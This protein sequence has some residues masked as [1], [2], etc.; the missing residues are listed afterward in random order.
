MTDVTPSGEP[1]TETQARDTMPDLVPVPPPDAALRYKEDHAMD[2]LRHAPRYRNWLILVLTSRR[3]WF[4]IVLVVAAAA[5]IIIPWYFWYRAPELPL[6]VAVVDKTVPFMNRRNHRGLFWLLGQ[7]KFV[8]G[9]L[10]G[11][12]RWYMYDRDYI[13]FFPVELSEVDFERVE[14]G[15]GPTAEGEPAEAGDQQP[16]GAAAAAE[17]DPGQP[18]ETTTGTIRAIGSWKSTLLDAELLADRDVLYLA[19]T[20]GVYTGDY[21]QFGEGWAST[22]HTEKIFGGM[23][24]Q[25]A[26]AVEQ[27]AAE[28]KLIVAEFNCFASPTPDDIRARMEH[29]L[30]VSWTR[31]IGRYF[32]D[33]SDVKD[34]PYWLLELWEQES[35]RT[36]DLTGSGYMLCRDESAEFI[37]LKDGEDV[38]PRHGMKLV[39]RPLFMERDVLQGVKPCTFAYW[40]DI[41]EPGPNTETLADYDFHVTP[42][43]QAKLEEHGLKSV[44]PAIMRTQQAY[45]PMPEP[46]PEVVEEAEPDEAAAEEA[47]DGEPLAE[48]PQVPMEPPEGL[49]YTVYYL[50][51]DMVDFDK[52]MGP[53][54]TRLT[55]YINRSFHA[56][57][58]V[59]SQGYFFWHTY[60]PL[61]TNILR[62]ESYRQTG[63]PLNIYLF[64]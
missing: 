28:G 1:G 52:A 55:M 18:P 43:G 63:E 24:E 51:G 64:D 44:F 7:N 60:Y 12:E 5:S 38:M 3:F 61:M 39:P 14:N 32:L 42:Q 20:Y 15:N 19:D 27:F 33:F 59:G 30:G 13:G 46:L 36:W 11:Q 45:A 37:I 4:V 34:V 29:V 56:Q 62:L 2:A 49:Y 47:R 9:G 50:A 17:P 25:E 16:A 22:M 35:G 21:T 8:D 57:H 41:V 6:G 53:S 58:V 31:W 40:F 23:E 48:E 54:N 10:A 26:A